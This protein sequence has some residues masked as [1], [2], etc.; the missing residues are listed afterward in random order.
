MRRF[1]ISLVMSCLFQ[2]S[3]TFEVATVRPADPDARVHSVDCHDPSSPISA[4]GKGRC[5]VRSASLKTIILYAYGVEELYIRG[6][7][8]WMAKEAYSIEAKAEDPMTNTADL[9]RML[10]NLLA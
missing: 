1:A 10:Q 3:V 6:G 7:P 5:S 4:A 8:A 2:S 9:K